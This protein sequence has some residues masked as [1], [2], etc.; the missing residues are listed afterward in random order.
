MIFVVPAALRASGTTPLSRV[1]RH[2]TVQTLDCD[3]YLSDLKST[4]LD[5]PDIILIGNARCREIV[6]RKH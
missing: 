4:G 5:E 1:S 6:S 2:C 3:N